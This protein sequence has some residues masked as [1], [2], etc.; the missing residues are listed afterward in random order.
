[1]RKGS[2]VWGIEVST[3]P[4]AHD[5]GLS[6]ATTLAELRRYARKEERRVGD[7]R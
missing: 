7:A 3:D 5:F 6:Q 2:V 1:M 4:L